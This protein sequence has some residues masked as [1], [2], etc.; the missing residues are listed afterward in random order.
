[1]EVLMIVFVLV[2]IIVITPIALYSSD[3]DSRAGAV[4]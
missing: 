1:M 2:G 3:V 4:I